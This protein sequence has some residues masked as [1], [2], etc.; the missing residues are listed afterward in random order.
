MHAVSSRTSVGT[1][2]AML[3]MAAAAGAQQP[4]RPDSAEH[5]DECY[6]FLFGPWTPPLDWTAAGHRPMKLP[7]PSAQPGTRGDASHEGVPRDS[8][9]ML[10]PD[11]WPVGV[12]VRFRA[13]SASGDT[14]HGT[15]SALVADAAARVPTSEVTVIRVP[16]R[17]PSRPSP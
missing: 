12:V 6:R 11:W 15:A 1:A 16:C 14:L 5:P 8:T 10:Y 17:P 3:L 4:Q 9:L 7:P 13:H 2:L